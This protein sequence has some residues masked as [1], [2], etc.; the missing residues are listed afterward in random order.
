M[1]KGDFGASASGPKAAHQGLA[2]QHGCAELTNGEIPSSGSALSIPRLTTVCERST[3]EH[4]VSHEQRRD[5]NR[6]NV[7]V[8]AGLISRTAAQTLPR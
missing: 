4:E 1:V 3:I 5:V 7:A 8:G 6:L 2:N